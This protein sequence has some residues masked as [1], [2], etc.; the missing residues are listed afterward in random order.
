ME[1]SEE[2]DEPRQIIR[3]NRELRNLGIIPRI[4]YNRTFKDQVSLKL[5]SDPGKPKTMIEA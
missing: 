3:M 2:K 5:I 1:E 4:S